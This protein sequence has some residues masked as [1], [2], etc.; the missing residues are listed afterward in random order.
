M[1]E[2]KEILTAKLVH[3]MHDVV[4]SIYSKFHFSFKFFNKGGSLVSHTVS[5][6]AKI[7]LNLL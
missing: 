1:V 2:S 7:V 3:R 4:Y 6:N 5:H